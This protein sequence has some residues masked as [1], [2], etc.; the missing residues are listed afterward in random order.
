MIIRLVQQ[1]L[2][3]AIE[4]GASDLHFEPAEHEL[5]VRAR[6]RRQ[7]ACAGAFSTVDGDAGD[8]A[9]EAMAEVPVGAAAEPIDSHIG[10]NLVWGRAVDL[11]F[12]LV[13][14]VTGEKIVLRVLERRAR[15]AT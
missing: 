13:P 4:T 14:S 10:Y 11:R 8:G 12:S 15:G 1:L 5:R 7:P 2:C 3:R 6:D 9:F